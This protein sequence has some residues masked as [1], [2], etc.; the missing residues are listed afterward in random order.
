MNT[1]LSIGFIVNNP[2]GSAA[3]V[4][5]IETNGLFVDFSVQSS[6]HE[7]VGGNVI[8][9]GYVPS[10]AEVVSVELLS[11]NRAGAFSYTI[12]LRFHEMT[13][14]ISQNLSIQV[15]GS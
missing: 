6:T 15:R 12:I 13:A 11:P 7:V 9:I 5:Y 2:T 3:H 1:L 14:P 8:N 4:A 10:G